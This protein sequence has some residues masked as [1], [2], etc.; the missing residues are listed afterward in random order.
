VHRPSA[1]GRFATVPLRALEPGMS[2]GA[3]GFATPPTPSMPPTQ[4]LVTSLAAALGAGAVLAQIC[5]PLLTGQALR[6]AT[7]IAVLLFAAASLTHA[8][9]RFGLAAGGVRLLL[10]AGGI[11]LVAEALGVATGI[12]FGSY[13]YSGTLGPALAGV[14]L[15]VPLAWTMM[16]YPCLLLGRRLAATEAAGTAAGRTHIGRRAVTVLTGAGTLAGWDLY[17]DPQMVAAGHWTW[18][19]PD[20][21]LPGVPTV[22]VT[23]LAGWLLVSAL[24]IVVLDLSLPVAPRP[25]GELVPAA[26]LT[27]TWIGS[28]IGNLAFFDR[29]A[30]ACYG[31]VAMGVFTLPYLIEVVTD[32]TRSIAPRSGD[33]AVGAR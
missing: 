22:P 4:P 29:P 14:P 10:V 7:I 5:Y 17:L 24:I 33:D 12:P 11:G 26:L 15:L 6:A 18:T 20:P 19:F 30:V 1:P 28:A 21:A 13:R 8:S 27:W 16:A 25:V 9:A 2:A 32:A 3:R 31:A 23:N